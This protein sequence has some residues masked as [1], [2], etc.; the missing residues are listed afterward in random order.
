LGNIDANTGDPQVGWDTDEFL[1]D[2]GEATKVML[3]VV[4]NVRK[5]SLSISFSTSNVFTKNLLVNLIIFFKFHR[6]D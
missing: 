5:S 6:E 4:K 2:I 1:T 3:S